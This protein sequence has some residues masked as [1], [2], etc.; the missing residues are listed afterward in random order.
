MLIERTDEIYRNMRNPRFLRTYYKTKT[1]SMIMGNKVEGSSPPDIFVG[2]YGYP[3]VFIGPLIPPMFGNT[4]ILS[5]PEQWLG[6]DMLDIIEMRSALVRGMYK[7]KVTNVGSGRTEEMITEL[8]IAS[9][10]VDTEA[11]FSHVPEFNPAFDDVSQPFGPSAMMKEMQIGN[12][13]ADRLIERA[14]YDTDMP[15]KEAIIE[16]YRKGAAVS[17]IQK[18]LSGGALGLSKNR[19]FVPTRWSITAIDDTISKDALSEVKSY[20]PIDYI[21]T[22]ENEALD[23]R[24]LIIML[25]GAWSYELIEAW[26]PRTVWNVGGERIAIYSSHEFFNGRKTY[27]EIGGCYYAARLATSELLKRIKRQAT[28]VILRETHEG[29]IMPV[30]VWNVREHVREALKK[31]P[32]MFDSI[33]SLFDH[34]KKRMAIPVDVWVQNSAVLQ[35]VLRQRRLTDY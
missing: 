5:T 34:V 16:L 35:Y 24:W 13:K 2:R 11:E 23:N 9:K 20:E 3:N 28:V 31:K 18:A 26:Y 27:A 29:Y 15:A 14:Y 19:K 22:Y 32:L 12:I 25:P 1:A 21:A 17:R 7:T 10:N 33:R 6:K 4:E 8:A 30:G